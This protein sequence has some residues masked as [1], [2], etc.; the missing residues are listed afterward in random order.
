MRAPPG[1]T[2]H[3]PSDH[4]IRKCVW[5][6]ERKSPVLRLSKLQGLRRVERLRRL[7]ANAGKP[8]KRSHCQCFETADFAK[9]KDDYV[10]KTQYFCNGAGLT[11]LSANRDR[12]EES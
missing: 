9:S 8:G 1:L 3:S 7:N 4:P 6:N 5:T 11:L 10:E 2:Q 12:S